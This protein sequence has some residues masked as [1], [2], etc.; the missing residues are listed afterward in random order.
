MAE[1]NGDKQH[2]A[3]CASRTVA[4]LLGTMEVLF[5]ELPITGNAEADRTIEQLWAVQEA[6]EVFAKQVE[7]Y[8]HG[9]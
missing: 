9:T 2:A 5:M 8:F 1:A 6:A 4:A 3:A 7:E